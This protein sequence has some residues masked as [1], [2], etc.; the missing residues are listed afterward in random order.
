MRMFPTIYDSP[1]A[2]ERITYTYWFLH[3]IKNTCTNFKPS[4]I[5]PPY[6]NQPKL[7]EPFKSDSVNLLF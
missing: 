1:N 4:L 6:I 7:Q 3:L 5:I 2:P